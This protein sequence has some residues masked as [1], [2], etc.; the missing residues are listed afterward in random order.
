MFSID[1]IFLTLL[2]KENEIFVSCLS[3]PSASESQIDGFNQICVRTLQIS[4]NISITF[5]AGLFHDN[6]TM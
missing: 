2:V 4:N 5:R 6:D 3:L 1:K